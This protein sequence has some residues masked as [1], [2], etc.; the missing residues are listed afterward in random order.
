MYMTNNDFATI[1]AALNLAALS[2]DENEPFL[3]EARNVMRDLADKGKKRN[4]KFAKIIHER[5][6][7]NKMYGRTPIRLSELSKTRLK[8]IRED[9][10]L[11][12]VYINDYKNRYDI[13]PKQ[14]CMFFDGYA[15]FLGE[16]MKCD[17]ISDEEFFDRL[18]EY[19]TI[20]NLCRW[21]SIVYQH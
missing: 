1:E 17:G 13:D 20:D 15:E 19:D 11:C 2:L 9:V 3:V 12:S 6:Q 16:E 10:V 8:R 7:E 14:V 4:K 5:R 21:H 18:N